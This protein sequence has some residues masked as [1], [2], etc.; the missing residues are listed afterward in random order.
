MRVTAKFFATFKDLMGTGTLVLDFPG[1][2]SVGDFKQMLTQNYPILDPVMSHAIISR[3]RKFAQDDEVIRD[4]DEIAVFPPVSGGSQDAT[5]MEIS[6]KELDINTLIKRVTF[7]TTGAVCT[8]TGIVR[9]KDPLS[10]TNETIALEYEAYLPMGLEK[11]AQIAEE[12]RSR[13]NKVE[14]IAV[15]QRIG[16]L[17]KGTQTILIACSAA[18]RDDGIFEA[19][20]YGIDRLKEIVP[21]WKK[22]IT[23][24]GAQ[25]KEGSYQP[26]L[27]D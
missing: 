8:F 20:R 17:P 14:G 11:I 3:N 18:H 21:I 27:N 26:G 16:Y 19:A 24:L 7:P 13:W 10:E 1:S 22:E 23:S 6:E 2:I 9:E 5:Y 12:I 4:L 25:W 15:M